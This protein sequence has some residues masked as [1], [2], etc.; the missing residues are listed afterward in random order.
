LGA[1]CLCDDLTGRKDICAYF[2]CAE[3]EIA[4]IVSDLTIVGGRVVYG[5]GEFARHDEA[6]LPPAM[7]DW[8]P[9]RTFGGYAAWAEP[10]RTG[11]AAHRRK[12]AMNRGCASACSIH[13]QRSRERMVEQIADLKSFWGALAHDIQ[14]SMSRIGNPCDKAESFIKTL[15]REEVDGRT[16]RDAHHAR[17]IIGTSSNRSII[18]S[19]YSRR[20]R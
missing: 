3:G 11:E 16:Y 17:G 5:A 1:I 4:N 8:S 12:L 6:A 2:S 18:A 13:G 7:P 15:K 9:V 19:D 20:P 10:S 14:P